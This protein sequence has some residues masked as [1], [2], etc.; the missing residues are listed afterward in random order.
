MDHYAYSIVNYLSAMAIV[1]LLQG[2]AIY[3]GQNVKAA[4]WIGAIIVVSGLA[5]AVQSTGVAIGQHF[6]H[7]DIYHGIQMIGLYLFY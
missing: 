4:G 7:N 5:V 3:Q 2:W 1:L 6:N